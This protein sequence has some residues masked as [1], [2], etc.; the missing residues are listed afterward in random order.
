MALDAQRFK[1]H[2]LIIV[3]DGGRADQ[4]LARRR[5]AAGGRLAHFQTKGSQDPRVVLQAVEDGSTFNFFTW[6]PPSAKMGVSKFAQKLQGKTRTFWTKNGPDGVDLGE[7]LQSLTLNVGTDGKLRHLTL[8]DDDGIVLVEMSGEI[9]LDVDEHTAKTYEVDVENPEINAFGSFSWRFVRLALLVQLL[10]HAAKLSLSIAFE[11]DITPGRVP[12]ARNLLSALNWTMTGNIVCTEMWSYSLSGEPASGGTHVVANLSA[13]VAIMAVSYFQL[14]EFLLCVV[15]ATASLATAPAFQY[16]NTRDSHPDRLLLPHILWT[17]AQ[18]C[19]TV[20]CFVV[21]GIIGQVYSLLLESGQSLAASFFLPFGTAF[22][23]TG[24]V[25]FTRIAYDRLVHSKKINGQGPLAGD[26]IYVAAPCLIFSA[27]GFAEAC[28]LAATL[29]GA[30]NSGGFAWVPTTCLGVALNLSA[31][32][33]WSRFMLIQ[34]TKKLKGGPAAMAIFAP[35]GWSKFHDELKIYCG[36]YRFVL[37]L[38]LVAVRAMIYQSSEVDGPWAPAFNLSATVLIPALMLAEVVEDEIVTR[39][40]LPVNP[41]G[42]GLL[43]LNTAGD[44]ADPA[45]LIT[46]EHLP[47]VPEN[48]PWK[49]M[50]LETSGRRSKMTSMRRTASASSLGE[51][52]IASCDTAVTQATQASVPKKS[53]SLGISET[54]MWARLRRWFGQP[55][56]LNSSAALHGLR[57]LP[58]MIHLSFIGI[59]AEFTAG[60]LGLLVGAGYIRGICPE[61]LSGADRMMGLLWWDAPLPC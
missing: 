29:A 13:T 32:L 12:W 42:P 40:L 48:D 37:V 30:I 24:M 45:Q 20:G 4:I 53:V 3:G 28:R 57:E 56:A 26:Q 15:G 23:E 50:E 8:T 36:Y 22:G 27:H 38:A 11:Q 18:V 35:T 55:R 1:D 44:N 10:W 14:S 16:F 21:F 60:L 33:G 19:G 46:L 39:E 47:N 41:A 6:Q 17:F 7:N 58:F 49:M 5:L 61:P 43:K 54:Y 31:R 59:V 25:I 34:L 9:V 52:G 2:C 51:M